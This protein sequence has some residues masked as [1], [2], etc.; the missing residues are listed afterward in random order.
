MARVCATYIKRTFSCPD[1][2]L[3]TTESGEPEEK[4]LVE[5]I[6]STLACCR[7]KQWHPIAFIALFYLHK[8]KARHSAS[9][10]RD[11]F[12]L[13]IAAFIAASG[14][15]HPV[16]YDTWL[17]AQIGQFAYS[18]ETLEHMLQR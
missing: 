16:R 4:L 3:I 15:A 5:L 12:R 8:L 10:G 17:W 2:V 6:D 1:T 7:I 13:F 9:Q 11:G 14:P 18:V